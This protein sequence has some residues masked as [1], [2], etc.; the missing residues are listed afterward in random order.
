MVGVQFAGTSLVQIDVQRRFLD[1]EKEIQLELA[2]YTRFKLNEY[3]YIGAGN[4]PIVGIN[5]IH[6]PQYHY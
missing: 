2:H 3:A 1:R 6:A 5:I 4:H